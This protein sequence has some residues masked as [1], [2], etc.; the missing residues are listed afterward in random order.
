MLTV[1]ARLRTQCLHTRVQ[2]SQDVRFD[3]NEP[4]GSF[5]CRQDASCAIRFVGLIRVERGGQSQA[6]GKNMSSGL[7]EV[8]KKIIEFRK[9]R[10]WEQFHDPKNLAEAISIEAGELLE[11]FLWLSTEN[12]KKI[13]DSKLEK[14]KEE[15]AD[16]LIFI[17]YMCDA[18]G[19]ELA[20]E[21]QRKV[22]ANRQKYPVD[23]SKGSSKKY[24]DL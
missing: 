2:K 22:E 13:T 17:V 8:I 12:S 3:A 20:E 16:I 5:C 23:K 7:D 11:Q 14:V 1:G 21:V 19:I 6:C 4:P 18:L 24:T 10:D 9:E 15:V